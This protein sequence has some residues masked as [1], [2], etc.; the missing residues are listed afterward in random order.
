MKTNLQELINQMEEMKAKDLVIIKKSN[1][2]LAGENP[3][4][5]TNKEMAEFLIEYNNFELVLEKK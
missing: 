5:I 4:Q 3:Y 2:V 1:V